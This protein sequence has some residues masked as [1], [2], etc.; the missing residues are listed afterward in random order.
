MKQDNPGR[1][2]TILTKYETKGL[3]ERSEQLTESTKI[4]TF[5]K[6]VTKEEMA[7]HTKVF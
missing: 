7:D 6:L 5:K 4:I 2:Q 1:P 3:S